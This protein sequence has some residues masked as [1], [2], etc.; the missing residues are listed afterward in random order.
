MD[1][2][3]ESAGRFVVAASC[4][5][6]FVVAMAVLAREMRSRRPEPLER[7]SGP[8]ALVNYAGIILFV[9]LGLV[10]AVTRWASAGRVAEPFDDGMRVAGIVLLCAAAGLA[11]WGIRTM[12]RHMASA[13]EVRPDTEIVTGGPFGLVRHPLYLSVLLMWLGG[14]LALLN[15]VLAVGYLLLVPAFE[16]RARKEE[17]M[18]SR[19][20]GDAY[21]AYARRVPR[22][23]PRLH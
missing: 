1:V 5:S 13:A 4:V 15:G 22:L 3:I 17:E 9:V 19:H 2:T 21:A 12:G 23:M 11:L 7:D 8:L 10:F 20:F 6:L 16:L 18:L 14:A